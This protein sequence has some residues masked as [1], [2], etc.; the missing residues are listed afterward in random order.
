MVIFYAPFDQAPCRRA[1]C[2]RYFAPL[3]LPA[4]RQVR[5]PFLLKRLS[6]DRFGSGTVPLGVPGTWRNWGAI[7]TSTW[8]IHPKITIQQGQQDNNGKPDETSYRP[9]IDSTDFIGRLTTESNTMN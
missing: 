7:P 3:G 1:R 9:P 2:R 4:G 6:S 8:Q 5:P